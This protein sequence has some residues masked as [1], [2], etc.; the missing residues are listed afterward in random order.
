[1]YSYE[2]D[3]DTG[4]YVLINTQAVFS[5]EPRP[6]YYRELDILGFDEFWNY[7]KDDSYPYLWAEANNYFYRGRLVAKTKGGSLYTKPEIIIVEE[8]EPH[9]QKLRF[10]D[11][12]KMVA[13]N[14]GIMDS[15]VQSTI[16]RIFNT[17]VKYKNKV[18]VFYVA[19]SGG[20]DSV[21]LL[22]LVLRSIPHGEFKVLF[23]DTGMEFPDTYDVVNNIAH[24][25]EANQIDFR[26]AKSPLSPDKTWDMFGPP[27][28]M[29][30]WCCS[31]HKT[32]PQINLLRNILGLPSFTG[33]AFTGV[34]GDESQ[35]RSGYDDVSYGE[36]H[37]GQY[38]CHPILEWNS[39]ELFLYI[40]QN[41]LLLNETYKKGNSRAGCLMCPM[42]S[43]KHEYM[44]NICY[45][46]EMDFFV[47][48]IKVTSSKTHFSSEE[49]E[50]FID[51]GN[52]KS[53]KTGRE[54]N[55]GKDLYQ[56]ETSGANSE[57]TVWKNDFDWK[58]WAKTIGSFT[59]VSESEYRITY[60]K[61]TYVVCTQENVDS[62]AFQF[63]GLGNS[64]NDIKFL[65]LFRSVIIKS[66]YCVGCKVCIA[67]CKK[68]CIL[69][70]DKLAISDDCIHCRKCHEIQEHCL[71]YNSIRNKIGAERKMKGI[72]RYFSFGIRKN[73]MATFFKHEG[74]ESFWL[75]DGDGEVANKKKDA[76]L[77]F[78]KDAD[79]VAL[80]R[81]SQGDKYTKYKPTTIAK[82]LIKMGVD[83]ISS[84][85]IILA[86][87]VYTPQ[88]NW[89]VKNIRMNQEYT[90]DKIR[91]LLEDVM[92][93]DGKGLGKR[94]VSDAIK[95]MMTKTPLGEEI[96][97]GRCD[98]SEKTNSVGTEIITLNTLVRGSWEPPDPLVILYSLY[99]FA[100]ACDG[101][102]QFTISRLLNHDIES[103]GV[104]PIEIFGIGRDKMEQIL[105]GLATNYPEFISV[106]FT[107]DLDNITL[108]SDKSS[109]DV[110]ALF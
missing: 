18:N 97:L 2:W 39:A 31:V 100:E 1:M 82:N 42:S 10:V 89:Y 8:P 65:S 93:N 7:D 38:S 32:A 81:N 20:K 74:A 85:G 60:N 28:T 12:G 83:D 94:N 14:A 19:F 6:V 90:Q 105:N 22:D 88:F 76:F 72:D 110:L 21:T 95:I 16:K 106:S 11:I 70:D 4:G 58:E 25:C 47:D 67:E 54:L 57:I 30:R 44:K 96:G 71:R 78:I 26:V 98:Y 79:L 107:L 45:P 55:F 87:L 64:K 66:L 91:L 9:R 61:Q 68:Q 17:Y 5:K 43:G 33:M 3:S 75:S 77:N 59:P 103:N 56:V 40:F 86:N 62:I 29:N 41:K 46:S 99:K 23:G 53:R 51:D 84:W 69:M 108:R 34:R 80:D 24:Y 104:S 73:W 109:A 49:L 92:E 35:A 102:Y 52:W 37:Q 50:K 13:K 36:K 48:K 101:Y 27:A 63:P 15:L